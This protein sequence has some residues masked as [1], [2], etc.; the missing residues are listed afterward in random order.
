MTRGAFHW[1]RFFPRACV[2]SG[3]K[4]NTMFSNASIILL[5]L[6]VVP[7][8]ACTEAS[9]GTPAPASASAPQ[10]PSPQAP[11]AASAPQADAVSGAPRDIRIVARAA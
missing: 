8:P 6:A 2:E 7:A 3:E 1:A 5:A 10:A 4:G 11:A 9:P